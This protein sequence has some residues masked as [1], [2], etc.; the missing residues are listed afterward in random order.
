MFVGLSLPLFGQSLITHGGTP[1]V[2]P[3]GSSI[4]FTSNRDGADDVFVISER[5]IGE[6]QL[7]RT[8]DQKGLLGWSTDGQVIFSIFNNDA[9]RIYT[10]GPD[11]KSQREIG[12]VP[13]HAVTLSPDGSRILYM[14]GTWTAPRL[15]V[16]A[17]DGSSTQQITDGSSIAWNSQW[18]PDGKRIAFTGRDASNGLAVII[19]NSDGSQRRQVTH[20]P[21]DQGRAQWPAWSPDG[22]QLAIQVNNHEAHSSQLW[23]LDVS[24][25]EAHKLAAHDQP[26]LDETPSWF[27]DG[28]RIAFQSNRTGRMEIWVANMD[29][30][31][32]RE[33]TK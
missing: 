5:G 16:S 1:S 9:S 27:P 17:L 33:V 29:G 13:G 28:K 23:I 4:A 8:V 25:G 30:T 15:T 22:R 6:K 7:T 12:G 26:Y 14:A 19:M 10:I 3:D 32:Q 2:F 21:T 24:T 31:G 20:F 11:G 18:S